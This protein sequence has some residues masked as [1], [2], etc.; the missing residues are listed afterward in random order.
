M[1]V[2]VFLS[3]ATFCCYLLL[4]LETPPCLARPAAA[5]AAAAPAAPAARSKRHAS[6]DDALNFIQQQ[7]RRLDE[8]NTYGQWLID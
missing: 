7:R 8:G 5:A 1:A 6:L 2:W 4:L 3:L